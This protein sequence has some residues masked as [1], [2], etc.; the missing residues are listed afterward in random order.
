MTGLVSRIHQGRYDSEKELLRLRENAL[1]RHRTDVLDAVHQRLKKRH[2]LL[3][4]RLVGPLT[5]R[6]RDKKFKCYCNNPKSLRE[7]CLDIMQGHVHYHSLIFCTRVVAQHGEHERYVS[8]AFEV[9]V[10]CLL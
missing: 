1:D 4:Q 5:D 10:A 8:S 7:I 9:Y 6:T 3:Y 2:P